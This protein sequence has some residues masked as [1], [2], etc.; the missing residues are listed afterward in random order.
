[1]ASFAA[2]PA[3]MPR[4]RLSVTAC[5]AVILTLI[6]IVMLFPFVYVI[7]VSFSSQKDVRAGGLILYPLH[8]TLQAYRVI[9]AGSVITHALAVSLGVTLIGTLI[10]MAMTTT[11][12]Y[13][14]SRTRQVP[15]GRLVLI[16]ALGT[17][18]F[19]PGIIPSYLLVRYLGLLNNYAALILPGMIN[20]F[21]LIVIRQFFMSIPQ[22]LVD[23]AYIDGANPLRVFRHLMLPLSKPVLAVIA[24]FYGV[25]YWSDYFTALLYLNDS[26][27]W[28]IQLVLRLY[29]LQGEPLTYATQQVANQPPPPGAAIQMAVLVLATAPIL[30]VY[31]FLQRYFTQ[32]VLSGAIKG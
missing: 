25:G 20:A 29:V 19:S 32:G 1:M 5:K 4:P 17:L 27:K 14:L 10:S 8:P 2:R 22:E 3:W 15:G 28:P 16:L 7:A 21:N 6:A 9:L 24:L 12:A 23:S 13:G 18:L 31:P 26:T 30:I 11:L